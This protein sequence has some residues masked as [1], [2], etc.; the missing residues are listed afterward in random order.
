QWRPMI[1]VKD[2]SAAICFPLEAEKNAVNGQR[3]NVGAN[4]N[5][6]QLGPLAE[7]VVKTLPKPVKIEW[8]G[9]PDHR[10]YRVSFDKLEALGFKCKYNARHGAME[11]YEALE[12]GKLNRSPRTSSLE[13]YKELE[14]W[15]RIIREAEMYGGILDI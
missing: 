12:S 6:Y 3:F 10:S 5:N 9:D 1:H 4:E 7:T 8:Y 11:V 2:T 13:W 14:K 15:H